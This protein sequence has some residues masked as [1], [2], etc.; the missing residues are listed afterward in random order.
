LNFV[1]V[2]S[3]GHQGREPRISG[4]LLAPAGAP[5]WPWLEVILVA[6]P[7]LKGKPFVR[8]VRKAFSRLHGARQM[9]YLL[10]MILTAMM[11]LGSVSSVRAD[12][13]E[14]IDLGEKAF[15]EKNYYEALEWFRK[16]SD[17][18]DASAQY[19]LG[20]MYETGTGVTKDDAEALRWIRLA[21]DQDYSVA[22]FNLGYRYSE[23]NGVT[24][25]Y[26][27]AVTWFERSAKNG[28]AASQYYLASL[29]L[30]GG[31]PVAKNS[32]EA[33]RWFR[34][35]ADQGHAEA[36]TGVGMMYAKGEGVARDIEESIKWFTKAGEQGDA[37]AQTMLGIMYS[38][39]LDGEFIG[40]NVPVQDYPI[41]MSW[42]RKA[43]EQ[44]D[45][46]A[47]YHL[48]VIYADGLGVPVDIV[49]AQMWFLLSANGGSEE[50]YERH[51]TLVEHLTSDEEEEMGRRAAQ[52]YGSNY[53]QC[54]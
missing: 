46:M 50:A 28:H 27:T 47:H 1:L 29:Y 25:N 22:Q 18:G 26:S 21:A 24:K 20:W 23:G 9:K 40:T 6:P 11:M 16:A 41:A 5:I 49:T 4:F 39:N 32:L 51:E 34:A 53:K 35:A 33:M 42:F 45:E 52:C 13:L 2:T 14:E 8:A 44:G 10:V 54:D 12:A 38:A 31:G 17:K 48:G 36:Q 43:A 15:K 30:K 3:R 7:P 19:F 37:Y